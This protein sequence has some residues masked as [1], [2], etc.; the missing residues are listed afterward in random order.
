MICIYNNRFNCY[1]NVKG[2]MNRLYKFIS[3]N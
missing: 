3:I 2:C 1:K